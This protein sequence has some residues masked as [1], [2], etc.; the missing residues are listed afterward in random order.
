[1]SDSHNH[2]DVE[3]LRSALAGR[4]VVAVKMVEDAEETVGK[5]GPQ[6]EGEVHLDD[7]RVLKLA[8][9]ECACSA[10]EYNLT[11]LNDMPINGIMD[12]AVEVDDAGVDEDG[13]GPQTYRL[14]VLAQDERIELA[15]FDGD[16]G[17][18]YY[19]TGFWF[20]VAPS[21]EERP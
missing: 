8:G 14:F 2:D 13:E 5:W 1:M 18:G 6:V 7:G 16:D 4:S 9:N 20:T 11:Q 21:T 12:V 10:G 15:T 19:G 3:A 17:N